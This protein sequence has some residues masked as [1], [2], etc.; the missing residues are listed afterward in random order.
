MDPYFVQKQDNG[1]SVSQDT[2]IKTV[3]IETV[4][5]EVQSDQ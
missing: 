2:R 4:M 5:Q 3:E 1:K